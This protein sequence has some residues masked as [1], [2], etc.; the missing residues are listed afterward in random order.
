MTI[1]STTIITMVISTIETKCLGQAN[2]TTIAGLPREGGG[3]KL[4]SCADILP[5]RDPILVR[6]RTRVLILVLAL[7]PALLRLLVRPM[8][9]LLVLVLIRVVALGSAMYLMWLM[10][11]P[12]LDLSTLYQPIC[13]PRP[14]N[15]MTTLRLLLP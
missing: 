4:G 13:S 15:P 9:L 2:Q 8:L 10:S 5:L 12:I 1:T 14:P 3:D 11:S 7:A 6:I